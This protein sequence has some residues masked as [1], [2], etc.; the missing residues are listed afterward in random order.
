[1]ID[2]RLRSFRTDPASSTTPDYLGL[3][4]EPRYL[5][6]L[7]QEMLDRHQIP[8]TTEELEVLQAHRIA[9]RQRDAANAARE[10]TASTLRWELW[11][12]N[13][14]TSASTVNNE[15][16]VS[17]GRRIGPTGVPAALSELFNTDR[18]ASFR[19]FIQERNRENSRREM[20]RRNQQQETGRRSSTILAE[21]ITERE[22]LETSP[23][24]N[25]NITS[26]T[27][28]RLTLATPLLDSVGPEANAN[29]WT[30]LA[31]DVLFQSRILADPTQNRTASLRIEIE[32]DDTSD[33]VHRLR[34]PWNDG[35]IG[36][37]D[38]NATSGSALG[39]QETIGC[40]WSENGRIL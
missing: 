11:A 16:P 3:D 40:T 4:L 32:E 39:R 26:S 28:E 12:G 31:G 24:R 18:T 5:R 37:R 36:I 38:G 30:E 29:P 27:L 19:S 1:V 13:Q 21:N 33:L 2:L 6:D 25:A 7:T 17:S 10:A 9:R 15:D 8:L 23:S 34:Q 14:R 35:L 20:E 22:T